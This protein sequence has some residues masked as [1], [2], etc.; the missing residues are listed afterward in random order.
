[1]CTA[2]PRPIVTL[3]LLLQTKHSDAKV[4]MGACFVEQTTVYTHF[5]I[6]EI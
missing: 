4:Y 6:Y 2:Q 3:P 5:L 1:M